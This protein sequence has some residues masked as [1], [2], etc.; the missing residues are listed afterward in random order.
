[1]GQPIDC[2]LAGITQ[3][4][5]GLSAGPSSDIDT[6]MVRTQKMLDAAKAVQAMCD[7]ADALARRVDAFEA[8]REKACVKPPDEPEPLAATS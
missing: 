1:M 6:G 7:R 5:P 2:Y 3:R 4:H 8:S